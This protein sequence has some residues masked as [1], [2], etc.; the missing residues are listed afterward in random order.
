MR[1]KVQSWY[2]VSDKT[3][4]ER[5]KLSIIQIIN[6]P[7]IQHLIPLEVLRDIAENLN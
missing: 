1:K 7:S 2:E 4:I 3:K 6:Y 5:L